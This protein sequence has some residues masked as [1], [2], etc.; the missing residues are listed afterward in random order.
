MKANKKVSRNT[1]Y[2][3][4][5]N[6]EELVGKYCDTVGDLWEIANTESDVDSIINKVCQLTNCTFN[7][8]ISK[9]LEESIETG[10]DFI[11][12]L[13]SNKNKELL[14]ND[15]KNNSIQLYFNEINKIY[16]KNNNN[17]D[18]EFCQENRDKIIEMNL[19]SVISIAKSY[20]GLG[21]DFQDLISA[22]NEG[23]LKA[24]DKY[25]P[26]RAKMKEHILDAIENYE[27]DK[28]TIQEVD[29]VLSDFLK[30]GDI[31]D[32]LLKLVK[33]KSEIS[34][35]ELL[36]YVKKNIHNAKFNSV[37]CKWILAYV[38]QEIDKNSRIVKKPKSEIDKDKE[39]LGVY[40][41]EVT[42]DID[43]PVNG[44]DGNTFGDILVVYDETKSEL[45]KEEDNK[46]FKHNLDLLLDGVKSRDR[47]IL[48]KKF[49]IG[50]VRPMLPNEIAQQENISLARVSQI[51][52]ST[53]DQM[54]KNKDKYNISYELL[55]SVLC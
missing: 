15:T 45:E 28:L 53:I 33:N 52:Q 47:R 44:D 50:I 7:T 36:K 6:N 43:A 41:K 3:F 13:T 16:K 10:N 34:K 49:G 37:A 30:Y 54:I 25:D 4:L 42:L 35:A 27:K 14:K 31:K 22:G 5:S 9:T 39:K 32:K 55:K 12:V 20:Q 17:Y 1:F 18:I 26:N 38:L 21:V 2:N 46:I 29:T 19:K 48:L 51:I 24:F 11:T 40:K 8:V 23:L